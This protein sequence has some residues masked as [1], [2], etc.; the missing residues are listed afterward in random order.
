V[1][2]ATDI[3]NRDDDLND[4]ELAIGIPTLKARM[5]Y[6][7]DDKIKF[8]IGDTLGGDNMVRFNELKTAFDQ[9][10]SDFDNHVHTNA[11]TGF[12]LVDSLAGAVS[13]STGSPTVASTADID[14]AKIEEIEVPEL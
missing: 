2:I 4:K 9:L 11:S 7:D 6:T 13:G 8:K 14:P 5:R 1:T 10:K 12:S 3:I